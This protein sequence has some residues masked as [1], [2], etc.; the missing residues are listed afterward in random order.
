H[1]ANLAA[2]V[3]VGKVGT[4]PI[5]RDELL[6]ALS[7]QEALAQADKICSP[8]IALSRIETWRQKGERIIFTNGCFD[9]LHAGHVTYLEKA[10]H[11]GNRLIVGLNTD[12]S[13][14]AIKG[15]TRPVI[16]QEDRARVLAALASVDLVLLF[17][18]PTPLELIRAL[19]PDVLAKGADYT[20]AQVV[21]GQEVKS[22][23]GRVAL[24]PLEPGRSSSNI[25]HHIQSTQGAS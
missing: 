12:R 21:G 2:G 7:S 18:Q 17:D 9:L 11:L 10:R 13:V 3:V 14:Q 5:H 23:G 6:A 4:S 22:W 15:P 19:R 20:E 8:E 16:R 24:I 25:L 1:L